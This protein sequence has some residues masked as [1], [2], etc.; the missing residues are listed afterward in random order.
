MHSLSIQ[1]AAS[2]KQDD[3]WQLFNLLLGNLRQNGQLIG[4]DMHPY[5]H[6]GRMSATIYTVTPGALDADNHN[7]YVRKTIR[8]L[9][10][11]CGSALEIRYVGESESEFVC[12]CV[13]S[14]YFVMTGFYSFSPI[15]CGGCSRERPV[16]RL[17]KL[18]DDGYHPLITWESN[19]R[20]C[21]ILDVNSVVG[22]RWAIKQQCDHDS[23]LSTQGRDVAGQIAELTRTPTYY[24]LPNF[25]KRSGGKDVER[26]CPNC[27]GGWHLESAI[28]GDITNECDVCFL[29][30]SDY[31]R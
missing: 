17:P 23:A 19:Y 6:A 15:I 25:I 11:L 2:A 24:Y 21:V 31:K 4:R 5:V 20:S 12:E 26:P 10:R 9:E 13:N 28:H 29:M 7:E 27:G 8:G 14:P 18:R 22:E 30:S 3:V 16:F 1:Y